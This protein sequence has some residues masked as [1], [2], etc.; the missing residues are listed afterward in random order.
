MIIDLSPWYSSNIVESG[1]K[2]NKIKI[3]TTIR[4]SKLKDRL[5]E[6]V[7]LRFIKKKD[8]HRYKNQYYIVERD[9]YYFRLNYPD[10]TKKLF[11]S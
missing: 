6:L 8:L 10:S 2:H 1:V 9:K 11:W 7:Q 5:K 3:Y 4:Q